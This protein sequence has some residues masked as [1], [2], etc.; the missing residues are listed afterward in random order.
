MNKSLAISTSVL[1]GAN[2]AALI[3][4]T[5]FRWNLFE[6]VL[7]Y[8]IQALI[9]GVFQRQ[10][11]RDM[12][13]YA[14]HPRRAEWFRTHGTALMQEGMHN[15]FAGIYGVFWAGVGIIL[16]ITYFNSE[17]L[18]VDLATILF[19]SS[20]FIFSHWW[21]YR[22]NKRTDEQRV[23]DINVLIL[24]MAR[25]LL[26]L[27]VFCVVMDLNVTTNPAMVATWMS[28]KTAADLGAH[29]KEHTEVRRVP[30]A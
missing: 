10:K 12:V 26:P 19:T 17:R 2:L 5:W 11:V 24:P 14:R 13:A 1:L 25:M 18:T 29:V 20:T 27:H 28:I 8:W 16:L 6:I 3:C 30:S 15:G 9:V 4:A 21:S 23:I 7:L 22:T